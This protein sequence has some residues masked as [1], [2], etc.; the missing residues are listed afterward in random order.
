MGIVGPIALLLVDRSSA[1]GWWPDWIKYV[2][3]TDF[4]LGATSAIV[5]RY[6]FEVAAVSIALN[7]LLYAALGALLVGVVGRL[8]SSGG[9]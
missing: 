1:H 4:M 6:W 3:P 5:D 9:Q 2:W 7:A 8:S